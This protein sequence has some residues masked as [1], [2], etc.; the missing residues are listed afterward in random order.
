M[1][2]QALQ[3]LGEIHS[4]QRFENYIRCARAELA[5]D[6]GNDRLRVF[7]DMIESLVCEERAKLVQI[8]QAAA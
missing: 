3:T 4:L 7:I 2:T 5:S 1:H 8:G 6:P